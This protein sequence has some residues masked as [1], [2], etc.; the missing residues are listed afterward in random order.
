[1]GTKGRDGGG[2]RAGMESARRARSLLR[3]CPPSAAA[4]PLPAGTR[5]PDFTLH[6]T[7]DQTVSLRDSRGCP[8][9]LAFYLAD[10]SPVCSEQLELYNKALPEFQRFRAQLLAIS[11]DSVRCHRAFGQARRLRFPLLA[12]FD[13]RAGWPAPI[14][15]IEKPT[16][17]AS[18]RSS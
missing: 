12:D 17:P 9:I 18:A 7:P 3:A 4:D 8:V 10:W 11:V 13:P 2:A 15:S 16:A 6:S 1:M 14:A 5:A